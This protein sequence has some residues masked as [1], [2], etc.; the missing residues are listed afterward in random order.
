MALVNFAQEHEYENSEDFVNAIGQSV[1]KKLKKSAAGKA[2]SP[3][4]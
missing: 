3:K 2:S 4:L 1:L